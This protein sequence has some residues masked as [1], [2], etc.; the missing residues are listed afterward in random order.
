MQLMVVGGSFAG[1][2]CAR[3]ASVLGLDVTV[4]DRKPE[5]GANPHTTGLLVDEAAAEIDIPRRFTRP[6]GGVRLYSPALRWVDLDSPGY[7]FHATDAPALMRWLADQAEMAGA[8]L[9]WGTRFQS[10]QQSSCGVRVAGRSFDF[11]VGA[12]GPRS[13]VAAAAGLPRNTRFLIGVE[14]EYVGVAGVDPDRLHV[15][16][17]SVL[18]PG[19]IAWVVPGLGVTQVGL[20]RTSGGR[21]D[22]PAFV[23]KMR[24]LFDFDDAEL[25][26]HRAG[27]IPVGGPLP[28][29]HT[30][31]VVLTGD[32]AGLVSPLTAGG[33]HNALRFG[34]L[35]GRAVAEHLF[36]GAAHPGQVI[37]AQAPSFRWK[38]RLRSLLEVSPPNLVLD[39]LAFSRPALAVARL[40][41][42]HHRGLFTAEGWRALTEPARRPDGRR[43]A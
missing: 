33:I 14:A 25:V 2:A 19:Y 21:P 27:P 3:T 43:A 38:A 17:D 15:F 20:A 32:A 37:S 29:I 24:A 36:E 11:L 5:P 12:D 23:A 8:D 6:I 18:A 16:L 35:T 28:R 31:R 39:R 34:R 40:V 10:L 41:F 30:D 42:F 7:R 22:L 1:L 4:V 13:R 26:S 9:N